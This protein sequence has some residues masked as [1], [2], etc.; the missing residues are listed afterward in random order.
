M[1]SSVESSGSASASGRDRPTTP[2]RDGPAT[3]TRSGPGF[4]TTGALLALVLLVSHLALGAIYSDLD[5]VFV[6]IS[7]AV[8]LGLLRIGHGTLGLVAL[9][10]ACL[11]VAFWTL[12]ATVV[13]LR[14]AAGFVAVAVPGTMAVLA[15]TGLLAATAAFAARNRPAS[16]SAA[17][18]R[19]LVAGGALVLGLVL[20]L[21]LALDRDDDQPEPGDLVV[22]TDRSAF[23]DGELEA[24]AGAVSVF[25]DNRDYF[26]HT[27]TIRAL[28]VDL[29]VPVEA[30]G[31]ASFDAPP[32]T[33]R[34]VCAVPGHETAG[35]VGTLT[36]RE[37]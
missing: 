22:I 17:G 34:F 11:N 18:P 3:P 24:D 20:V 8:A 19:W 9:V 10:L 25:M 23:Q 1:S 30:T 28:G 16:P 12:S 27:F 26:W 29:A 14:G 32:G 36:V 33:Y 2:E 7:F 13:N 4:R 15:V 31:R 6:A 21:G 37:P 35:M 5:A